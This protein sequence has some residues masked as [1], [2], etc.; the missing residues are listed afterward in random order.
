MSWRRG[1]NSNPRSPARRTTVFETAPFDR[2]G[3]SPSERGQGLNMPAPRN[4]TRNL[5]ADWHPSSAGASPPRPLG[6][7]TSVS[8][9][10]PASGSRLNKGR[11][12]L[13]F[14]LAILEAGLTR[15]NARHHPEPVLTSPTL[16]PLRRGIFLLW[17]V[18]YRN[19]LPGHRAWAAQSSSRS[20]RRTWPRISPAVNFVVWM[21]A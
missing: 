15:A 14:G 7:P 13:S 19:G 2:S 18:D 10:A 20:P 12:S 16:A 4:E 9:K 3:T 8:L 1:R 21:L 5:A 11:G 6:Q 17:P